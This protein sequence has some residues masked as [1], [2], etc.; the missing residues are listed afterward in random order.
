MFNGGPGRSTGAA[1]MTGDGDVISLGLGHPGRHRAHSNLGHQFDRDRCARIAV[2]KVVNQLRQ[3]F[4][5]INIVMRRRRNQPDTGYRKTQ[6]RDVV[7][8]LVAR[9]LTALT[10]L[11]TLRHFDLNLISA[12][13]VFGR[14]TK[15]A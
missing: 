6:A 5:R 10:R 1:I 8:D 14:D 7:G 15:P 3:V 4:N 13:Q 9:Q 2:F 12:D 11:G